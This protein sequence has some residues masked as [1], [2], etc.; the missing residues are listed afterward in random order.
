M[1]Y[2]NG[3][4]LTMSENALYGVTYISPSYSNTTAFWAVGQGGGSTLTVRS[5]NL[6]QTWAAVSSANP[7]SYTSAFLKS[8]SGVD[9]DD[10]W[11]VGYYLPSTSGALKQTLIE[12]WNGSSWSV[13]SSPN[14]SNK[15][16][17]LHSVS[18]NASDDIWAVGTLHD[19]STGAYSTLTQHWNGT[20]WSIVSSPNPGT[21]NNSFYGVT[22]LSNGD[23]WAVGTR[24]DGSSPSYSLLAFWNSSS[25]SWSA[26]SNPPSPG[27][28][29]NVL[30]GIAPVSS[31]YLW[32]VGSKRNISSSTATFTAYYR[33]STWHGTGSP[34]QGSTDNELRAVAVVPGTATCDRDI[35]AVGSYIVNGHPQTLIERYIN[36]DD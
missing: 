20:S 30:W 17:R 15:D 4:N 31:T 7:T 1:E 5:T 33:A 8:V 32:A 28:E 21:Q 13:V 10:V 6:G 2:R 3:P 26:L 27:S 19:P 24:D 36:C 12:H 25:Q 14:V 34:N 9:L 35:W 22:T 11:A 18:A 29:Q 23:A 16:N